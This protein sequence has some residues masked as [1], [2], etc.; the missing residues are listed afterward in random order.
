MNVRDK[1]ALLAR[2]EVDREDMWPKILEMEGKAAQFRFDFGLPD[3]PTEPG[4]LIIRGPRQYGKSTWLEQELRWT[5]EDFGKGTA[6]YLNGDD[7]N[8]ADELG[9]N[10]LKLETS[11]LK[12][13]KVKRI[14]IDEITA[15]P[16]W[17][18]GIKKI[19]D[20]GRL[21]DILLITTGSK[22][23]DLRRGS[24]RL[25][26]RKG[27]LKRTNYFFLPISYK[28]FFANC[29]KELGED[30]S[31]AYLLSGG[32]P[33]G[34]NDIYQ[35][36]RLPDY[37]LELTR[38]WVYG[39]IIESGRSRILLN[40]LLR[41]VFRYSG[42]PTG[43]AKLARESSMANNTVAAGY[44]EQLSDLMCL[45]P[46]W[47]WDHDRKILLPRKPAKFSFIN[48]ATAIAFHPKKPFMVHEF[49]GLTTS[50]KAKLMEWLVCQELWRREALEGK[51]PEELGFWQSKEHEIDFV[52][53]GEEFYEVK[54]GRA[55]P[56]DFAWFAK[57]F[58][59]KKLTVICETPFETKQVRGITLHQF[60]ME[61]KTN[62]GY[63]D[64]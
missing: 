28:E 32:S 60:L 41:A 13:A 19:I 24:E 59:K 17:E 1:N 48:L 6:F 11:F 21:K 51:N 33:I 7:L 10:L 23:L 27:R 45:I 62:L 42:T 50:E 2:G 25:P 49:K 61:G 26:G 34:A 64:D 5:I 16:E 14:F 39:E 43:F 36:E 57:I 30:A 3:L 53:S 63:L 20:Q 52:T 44:I 46:L 18:R 22:A 37:F 58:P 38:D 47:P 56:L 12:D 35:F 9:E 54:L 55:E 40:N 15:V 31:I 8:S 29:G 4:I